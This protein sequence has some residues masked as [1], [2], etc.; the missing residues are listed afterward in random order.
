MPEN[1]YAVVLTEPIDIGDIDLLNKAADIYAETLGIIKYDALAKIRSAMGILIDG[2]SPELAENLT[3]KLNKIDINCIS[4]DCSKLP[5]HIN[6]ETVKEVS[7]DEKNF[8]VT[9]VKGQTDSIPW[10]NI[11]LLSTCFFRKTETTEITRKRKGIIKG[12][13]NFIISASLITTNPVLYSAYHSVKKKLN[14]K[15][16]LKTVTLNDFYIAELLTVNPLRKLRIY[17]NACNYAYLGDRLKQK[18][19]R[20]FHQAISDIVR[21]SKKIYLTPLARGF[22]DRQFIGNETFTDIHEFEK[23]NRWCLLSAGS[24]RKDKMEDKKIRNQEG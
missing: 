7:A 21:Y 23:Y 24:G 3:C 8:T 9:T 11:R 2:T 19:E 22:Y 12:V 15:V 6:A 16:D 13:N 4:C 18:A 20:N 14:E 10:D 1:T 17:S 5:G